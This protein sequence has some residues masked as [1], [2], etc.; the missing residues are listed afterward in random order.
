MFLQNKYTKWYFSIIAKA[1]AK[2]KALQRNKKNSN[3]YYESHHIIPKCMG[4]IEQVL[5][6]GKEHFICHLLLCKMLVGTD[7]HKMINALIKMAYNKSS[8][9][10]RYTSKSYH[11]IRKLIAQKN[12]EMFKGVPKSEQTR[13]KM[14]QNNGRYIRTKEWR[15]ACSERQR[16]KVGTFTG[17]K[18]TKE[19][20][21]K[22]NKTRKLRGITPPFTG[23]GCRHYTNG[24]INKFCKPGLEPEGFVLGRVLKKGANK[25]TQEK[26]ARAKAAVRLDLRSA[27][28][29]N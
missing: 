2:A 24:T 9:Q 4:G 5:L 19:M 11:L 21:I 28:L 12:S 1:K 25:C 14:K 29:V 18:F 15:I 26:I 27:V 3:E 10:H 22:R 17:K 13:L 7:K 8:G 20:T 6:T 23:K 16:G